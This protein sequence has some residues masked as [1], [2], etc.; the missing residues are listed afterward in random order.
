MAKNF[1]CI[2]Y[3]IDN[4]H[5]VQYGEVGNSKN[6]N[7]ISSNFSFYTTYYHYCSTPS[8]VARFCS[9]VLMSQFEE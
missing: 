6:D 5:M 4:G 3:K 7:E 8:E 1:A 2:V 9:H